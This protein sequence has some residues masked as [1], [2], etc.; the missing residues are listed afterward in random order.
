[1]TYRVIL[2]PSAERALERLP[3]TMQR[4]ILDAL[5]RLEAG[6]RGPRCVK[7]AGAAATYRLRVGDWRV[8]YEIDDARHP[9]FVTIIAHRREV[10]RGL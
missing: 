6:P 5:A 1:M 7:P 10:Y 3:R 9:V 8:V 2:K 4:R